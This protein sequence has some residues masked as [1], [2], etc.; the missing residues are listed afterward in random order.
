MTTGEPFFS[1]GFFANGFFSNG[2]WGDQPIAPASLGAWCPVEQ[3]KKRKRRLDDDLDVEE[4]LPAGEVARLRDEMLSASLS[5]DMEER[6]KK[7]WK[8]M[9]AE[10]DAL[11]L[12]I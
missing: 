4:A 10:E 9:R 2:F 11:L 8:R 7:R 12:M 6:A 5:S 1:A 3:P